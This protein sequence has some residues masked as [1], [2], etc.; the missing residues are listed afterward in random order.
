MSR[1]AARRQ[2]FAKPSD[3][4]AIMEGMQTGD[5]MGAFGRYGLDMMSYGGVAPARGAKIAADPV[6]TDK[7]TRM[8]NG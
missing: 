6:P 4:V 3:Y 5:M 8:M 1:R 7:F 2:P